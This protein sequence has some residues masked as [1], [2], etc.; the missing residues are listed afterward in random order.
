[1][2]VI[3]PQSI[4]QATLDRLVDGE[5][6][7]PARAALL[8][9]LDREPDGWK[10]CAL[11]FLQAQA[12][13]EVAGTLPAVAPVPATRPGWPV[14]VLRQVTAVAAVV[15]VA[16]CAG[17]VSRGN[18]PSQRFALDDGHTSPS[19]ASTPAPPSAINNDSTAIPEYVRARME[20]EGYRVEG[21]RKVV[22]VALGD[23]RKVAVPVDTV[24]Y[25]FVGQRI[26]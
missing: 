8:R 19:A 1:M 24:S 23:G 11:A 21:G 10:R 4:D 5:M 7:E 17:F 9:A 12:W 14:R 25:R 22:E 15:A 20:R 6:D 3:T 16:F 18:G 26:H 2:S 13:R